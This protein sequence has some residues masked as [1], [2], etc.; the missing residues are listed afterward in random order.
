MATNDN[1]TNITELDFASIK[2]NLIEYL[3]SKQK[4]SG[5]DFEGSSMNILMDLLAYNTHYM[6]FYA[7][8]VGNEMF[9]DS[10]AK[11]DSIVSHAKL[12][13][14]IPR[15]QTSARAIINLQKS[16]AGTINR[17]AYLTGTYTNE[18]NQ[19]ITKVFTFLEDY[20]YEKQ[21]ANVWTVSDAIIQEGILQ[22]LT[23]VN[24]SRNREHKFLIPADADITTVRVKIRQSE[25]S[26]TDDTESW[27]RASDFTLLG[28]DEKVFFVQAAYDG[29]YEVYFGDGILG[30]QLGNGNIIYIEYL[31]NSGTN[32]NFFST[33]SLA[34]TTITTLLASIG[35]QDPEDVTEIRKNAP[36]AFAAQNRTVTPGDYES[37]IATIYPQAETIKVWGGEDNVPPQYGRV[38]VSIKPVAGLLLPSVEKKNILAAIKA[39]AVVGVVPEIVDPEYLYAVLNVTTTFDPAKTSLSRNE[40]VALQK[41]EILN[42]FD[43]T[44]EKFDVSL[45]GSKLNKL[46]D[47]VDSSIL[48][49]RIDTLIEQQIKPSIRYPTLVRLQF[50]NP[51][52]HPYEGFQGSF[53]STSF[54]YKNSVGAV[55]ICFLQDDGYGKISIIN[56]SGATKKIIVDE[57][58]KIDYYTG[59]ITL[60]A[61][62]PEHYGTLTHIKIRVPPSTDDIFTMYN[63]IITT[64]ADSIIV[65]TFTKDEIAR[66]IRSG[67]QDFN[68]A[69]V[70]KNK[71]PDGPV[72][73]QNGTALQSPSPF[74]VPN[75]PA[76]PP[77]PN[78]V[79]INLPTIGR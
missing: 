45:Y 69:L 29:Q 23:Y 8:M 2:S 41:A 66:F 71:I 56:G 15:S 55:K 77:L 25:N 43:T 9:L 19:S 18:E 70:A 32:G 51:L 68:E 57:A 53:R 79:S 59:N 44:L 78:A 3:K 74:F 6:A 13:N 60:F 20:E 28:P 26:V 30:S 47:S 48:G 33:F 40:I 75:L 12:L 67:T 21:S 27:Y 35:G 24:D 64:T 16:T 17:G 63:K 61:F 39:K 46:L 1:F 11:R 52:F 7:S 50:H 76:T 10:A 5:Y 49:T 54:G 72:V 31:Q 4:F 38:F 22:T 62:K 37:V 65:K 34:A 14:Y 42:Y 58:G 36:K 73:V